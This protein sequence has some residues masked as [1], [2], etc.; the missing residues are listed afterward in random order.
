[1]SIVNPSVNRGSRGLLLKILIISLLSGLILIA[2]AM[3]SST[4]SDRQEY[5]DAAV[6]SISDS[7][8]SS[9]RLV[10]P[11]LV[12]PYT[13]TQI[14]QITGKPAET[15]VEYEVYSIFPTELQ[16]HGE[17]V[18]SER[19]HGLYKVPVYE[20]RGKVEG[21][22]IVPAD[23]V[24]GDVKFEHPYLA[25]GVS[26]VRGL[27]GTP[28]FSVNGVPLQLAQDNVSDAPASVKL[29]LRAALSGVEGGKPTKLSF[30]LDLALAGTEHLSIAPVANSNHIELHSIWPSPLFE[31]NF[32]PRS[33]DVS[34][35]GF[36]ASWDISSLAS[37][38]Q[39]QMSDKLNGDMDTLVVSLLEPVDAYKLSSRAVKYGVLFVLL[40]FAGFFMY[41]IMNSLPIHPVQYLLIG[42]GLAIFFLLLISFSEHIA[43]GI[44]YLLSSIAC[45]GLLGFYLSF[46]LRN[47]GRGMVFS[48]LLTLLYSCL[49]GLLLSED[50]ALLLGSLLLFAILAGIMYVT[51]N[52]DW[53]RRGTELEQAKSAQDTDWSTPPPP[54][55]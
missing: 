33:R 35:G 46:V 1:M 22:F 26:D 11:V 21:T 49:Y 40:T 41:E 38:T 39:R 45:I 8:A 42:F 25:L 15:S 20:F 34:S 19:H 36:T 16:V 27:V 6:K 44:A 53:Y 29:P 48:I 31:G 24:T 14:V 3:I 30:S 37:A 50:N 13:R 17:I 52:V 54:A 12:Q 28:V 23:V 9:Q 10:G 4:I 32:L 55:P 47:V 2:L 7:Y 18:S 5:R 43:F 51:R